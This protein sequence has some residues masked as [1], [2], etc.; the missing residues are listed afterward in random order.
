[1]SEKI[2]LKNGQEFELTPMGIRQ[3]EKSRE[4]TFGSALSTSQIEA[5][6]TDDNISRIEYLSEAGEVLNTYLDCVA[7]KT[8]QKDIENSTYTIEL[9]INGLERS[10]KSIETEVQSNQAI[11]DSSV[12]ELTIMIANIY[13]IL[14]K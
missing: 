4:I 2:R 1:M 12:G 6:L 8:I 5:L 3:T 7:V 9:S 11:S 14:N 10:L 13:A